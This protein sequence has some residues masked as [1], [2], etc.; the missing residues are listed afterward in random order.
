MASKAV[1]QRPG[2]AFLGHTEDLTNKS[3]GRTHAESLGM[4]GEQRG[5]DSQ[6]AVPN[7]LRLRLRT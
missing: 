7:V 6:A 4:L 3:I 1:K 2:N 5:D